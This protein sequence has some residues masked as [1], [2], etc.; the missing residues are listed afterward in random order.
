M[1][2]SSSWN[3]NRN[4]VI[5]HHWTD[6]IGKNYQINRVCVPTSSIQHRSCEHGAMKTS[7]VEWCDACIRMREAWT[8]VTHSPSGLADFP[9]MCRHRFA[10]MAVVA[11]VVDI[12]IWSLI[13]PRFF[14]L[15]A[16]ITFHI[17]CITRGLTGID[18]SKN[19]REGN[20]EG[21]EVIEDQ[22]IIPTYVVSFQ[23]IPSW[24]TFKSSKQGREGRR[25]DGFSDLYYSR[26][27]TSLA[28][29]LHEKIRFLRH[30]CAVFFV[31]AHD[32]Q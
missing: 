9:R 25:I 11:Y 13:I 17:P 10:S 2:F 18:W 32:R 29:F 7:S 12:A 22:K 24:N 8:D 20:E 5:L 19:K 31:L 21:I 23:V 16:C 28:R 14:S 30:V 15:Y 6:Y 27:N 26:S 3:N 4:P 1:L